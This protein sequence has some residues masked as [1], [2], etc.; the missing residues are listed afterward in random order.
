MTKE[1]N[2]PS[3][4]HYWVITD[5]SN[6]LEHILNT[7]HDTPEVPEGVMLLKCSRV[8]TRAT[9]HK[10][11][12]KEV[13]WPRWEGY[14]SS[15]TRR[16]AAVAVNV[17]PNPIRK[18][19]KFN[20]VIPWVANTCIPGSDEHLHRLASSLESGRD[21]QQ[22]RTEDDWEPPTHTI[23]HVR[24]KRAGTQGADALR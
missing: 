2:Q 24:S 14:A 5:K 4:P 12:Y 23:G 21:D 9:H 13:A 6:E 7:L 8:N 18:L 20:R 16:G 3:M 22:T 11:L 17:R 10:V 15:V 1:G 19:K